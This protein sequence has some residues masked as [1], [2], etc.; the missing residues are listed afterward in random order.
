MTT[1]AG[2][3]N[4]D[5]WSDRP[6]RLIQRRAPLTSTPTKSV[7][8]ISTIATTSTISAVAPHLPRRQERGRDH[9]RQRRQE[10]GDLALDEMEA[11]IAEALGDRR[12]AGERQDDAADHQRRR[13]P[14]SR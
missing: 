14:P 4:S 8:S 11:V 5:G 13:A 2:F 10:E 1:K 3:M 9:H 6:A 12:A 7:A